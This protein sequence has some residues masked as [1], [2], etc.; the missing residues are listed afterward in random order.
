[1]THD[2]GDV[3]NSN[4]SNVY[5]LPTLEKHFD[6]AS[7]WVAK[8]DRGLNAEEEVAFKEAMAGDANLRAAVIHMAELWDRMDVLASLSELFPQSEIQSPSESA[9]LQNS[10][11]AMAASFVLV[12]VT[13]VVGLGFAGFTD[14]SFW[15]SLSGRATY[16]TAVGEHSTVNFPDGTQVVLNTNTLMRVKYTDNRRLFTLERGEIHIDVAHDKFRPLTVASGNK[17]IQA[18][19]TA[20][21]V[22]LGLNDNV[23]LIVTDGKV[24]AGQ[25][26]SRSSEPALLM[27]TLAT[28]AINP[29]GDVL[30]EA[31]INSSA[32]AVAKGERFV[33][34]TQDKA[35]EKLKQ[36]EIDVK[37]S[38]REGNL[39]FRGETL[40]EA[41]AEI[42]RYTNV[43]FEFRDKQLQNKRIAGLFKAGDVTGL[44]KALRD[45]FNVNYERIG[46]EKVILTKRSA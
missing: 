29:K 26:L 5:E 43:E 42:S 11:M 28:S 31:V 18:V 38:W 35:V 7:I 23:E 45:N 30:S 22:E 40:A 34:G 9:P 44:L 39:V 37:L 36:E 1:M 17:V 16:E 25:N 24:L 14:S 21:S 6:A 27:D 33:L 8:L 4:D 46:E 3:N 32:V 15:M 13:G 12:V 20:F 19:G 10:F 41:V 2:N